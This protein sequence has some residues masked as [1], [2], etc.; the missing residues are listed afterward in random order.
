MIEQI[1]LNDN[2]N[3]LINNN[4]LNNGIFVST[5]SHSTINNEIIDQLIEFG[6]NSLYSKR[7][8]QYYHPKN[9]QEAIDYLSFEDGKIQHVFVQER[10]NDE[11][12]ICYLCGEEKDIHLSDQINNS[13]SEDIRESSI[14][15]SFLENRSKSE[16][17]SNRSIK[18][19]NCPACEEDFIPN[20]NNTL[21]KCGHAF[22]DECWYDFLSIKIKENKLTSI[23]CMDYECNEKPDEGFIINL[24]HSNEE[25]IDKYKK[26]KLE[27]EIINDPNKKFCPF[28][29]CNSFLELKDK[30]NKEVKCSNNHIFCFLCLGKPH[31]NLPCNKE[32]NKSMIEYEKNNFVKKCPKCDIITEKITGCNHIIC[33][34]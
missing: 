8:F 7:I 11:N 32:I 2:S 31:G 13:L 10:N 6:Y 29:N 27:L 3:K 28:P 26:F 33:S 15:K 12:S 4:Q 34:K 14:K 23:K 22:C 1:N 18:K 17:K 5:L 21:K 25:L 9:V 20:D 24:L 16:I 30:N 19:G